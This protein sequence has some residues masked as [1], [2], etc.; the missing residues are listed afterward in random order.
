M[1]GL[2]ALADELSRPKWIVVIPILF[3]YSW[4]VQLSLSRRA[5][6]VQ[7]TPHFWDAWLDQI[8]HPLLFFF[9]LTPAWLVLIGFLLLREWED[10]LRIRL[11]HPAGWIIHTI[12]LSL[13]TLIV[14][15]ALWGLSGALGGIGMPLE[16]GWSPFQR[17]LD[18]NLSPWASVRTKTA[19]P[20]WAG[21]L[22]LLQ[23]ALYLIS[24][25]LVITAWFLWRPSRNTVYLSTTATFLAGII[26]YKIIPSEWYWLKLDSYAL[27]PFSAY[28]FGNLYTGLI[29]M[30]SFCLLFLGTAYACRSR[31]RPW[32]QVG[33]K[34]HG[35]RLLYAALCIASILLTLSPA[36]SS[37]WNLLYYSLYGASEQGFS[38]KTYLI[39]N[40]VFLGF[41]YLMQLRFEAVLNGDFLY[42][43]I[44]HSSPLRWFTRLLAGIC[45]C[46]AMLLMLYLLAV[47]T[48]GALYGLEFADFSKSTIT[49]LLLHY[50]V[51]GFM[52]LLLYSLLAFIVSWHA[53]RTAYSLYLLGGLL[54]AGLPALQRHLLLP[55][56]L[57]AFGYSDLSTPQLLQRG[58]T[59]LA[60]IMVCFLAI[61]VSFRRKDLASETI[62]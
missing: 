61:I 13:P 1:I 49:S 14:L 39:Y 57:S 10:T 60:Y 37:A 31:P 21:M 11:R 24:L 30:L 48:I 26:S 9:I 28:S 15:L 29:L 46:I 7:E 22:Q 56:A 32:L 16:W 6:W 2:K 4:L 27:L 20:A 53:G 50:F 52:Q 54:V 45:A 58:F 43:L 35:K 34:R 8:A 3:L 36:I 40:I 5:A 51:L 55:S 62:S 18:G 17:K 25:Q 19:F 12:S 44:R 59:L 23:T 33:L 47:I 42:L 41:T 38:L